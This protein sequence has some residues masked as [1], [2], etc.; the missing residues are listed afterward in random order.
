MT[1]F[2]TTGNPAIL[3]D[4]VEGANG[5]WSETNRSQECIAND[6]YAGG[7]QRPMGFF[8]DALASG[9]V[10][11]FNLVL[12]NGCEDG[13]A[14]CKPVNNRY[15]QFDLFLQHEIPKI[16]ASPAFGS[17]GMIVVTY[18]ESER[19]GG[20]AK[21]WG[22]GMGGHVVCALI[23]PQ[24]RPGTYDGAYYHYSLLRTLEDGFRVNGH[25]GYANDVTAISHVWR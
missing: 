13:E 8:N 6:I 14:N 4:N 20:L 16:E 25:V 3:Y 5:A 17:D 23:G 15:R 21:K 22:Y 12:P 9:T 10:P 2:Y 19:E 7:E 24:V 11:D 1:G 18:D